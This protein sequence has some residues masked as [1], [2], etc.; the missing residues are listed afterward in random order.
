MINWTYSPPK[1]IS[2]LLTEII[3]FKIWLVDEN[4]SINLINENLQN[5]TFWGSSLPRTTSMKSSSEIMMVVSAE[6][7]AGPWYTSP[8]PFF[9]S[10]AGKTRKQCVTFSPKYD[11]KS[12]LNG[13][14]RGSRVIHV[15]CTCSTS[16]SCAFSC[17]KFLLW[18]LRWG[19]TW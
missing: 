16:R 6:P 1:N 4:I 3:I 9:R 14:C 13:S 7:F 8:E 17:R 12:E 5:I 19:L 18:L 2:K 15:F 11:T 10:M